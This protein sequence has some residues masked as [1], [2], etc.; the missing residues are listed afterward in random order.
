MHREAITPFNLD[1][2]QSA[3]DD[4]HRRLDAARWPDKEVVSDWSQ[5]VPQQKLR[6]LVEYWRNDYDWRRLEQKLNSLGQF[7]TEIDGVSIHFL[8]VRSPNADAIP[9]I[10]T[11]GWPGSIVEF[12]ASIGPLS[13]PTAHG[14]DAADAF[15]LVIPSLPGFGFS[16][17]PIHAGWGVD[18]IADAWSKLM[19]RLGY[20]RYF[21]QGGDWGSAITTAMGVKRPDGLAGIHL[22]F[23]FVLPDPFPDQLSAAEQEMM[24]GV[25]RYQKNQ[26]GYSFQQMTRPQTLG[27]LLSDSPVGQAAWI[28]EKFYE[29]SDCMGNPLSAF[30]IDD[31][32][33]NIMMYWL[34]N[35]GASSSRIYWE[36][37]SDVFGARQVDIPVGISIFP[38]EI[39]K[40]PRS[41]AE[42]CMSKLIYWNELDR[43]GHFPAFEQPALFV[44]EV[45]L[46]F[47]S[48]RA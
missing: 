1:V 8:H 45:R 30:V 46:A 18:Q 5:G 13:D 28:Y 37:F 34:P 31:L 7:I 48:L 38:R 22:N 23:P 47:R 15:H 16:G 39:Y 9:L 17:K 33:D 25:D 42:R 36:S 11:H 21:A 40:A 14:G 24:A 20:N 10:L 12:L 4:L 19:K 27:Y 35:S 3:I 44:N 2:P 6:E 43:G 32:L 26:A 41:W 29:W